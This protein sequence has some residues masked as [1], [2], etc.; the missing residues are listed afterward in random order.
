MLLVL[1]LCLEVE[2]PTACAAVGEKK[3]VQ[4]VA[5][6]FCHLAATHLPPNAVISGYL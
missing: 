6:R 3:C 4:Q 2:K 5:S 1:N